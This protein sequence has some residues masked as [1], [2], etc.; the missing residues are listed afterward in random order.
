MRALGRVKKEQE[1]GAKIQAASKDGNGQRLLGV[2]ALCTVVVSVSTG[3]QQGILQSSCYFLSFQARQQKQPVQQTL[4][5]V[6]Q[7]ATKRGFVREGPVA[8]AAPRA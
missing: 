1:G 8:Q 5:L 6:A 2:H 7:E 3:G 4:K